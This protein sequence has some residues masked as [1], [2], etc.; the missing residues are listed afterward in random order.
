[1]NIGVPQRRGPP[2]LLVI[3][4]DSNQKRGDGDRVEREEGHAMLGIAGSNT[5][6]GGADKH[7]AEICIAPPRIVGSPPII[8]GCQK[9]AGGHQTQI[10][11]GP[12]EQIDRGGE[13]EP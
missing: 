2:T 5:F 11:V 3:Q 12:V 10:I 9:D 6:I 7:C 4:M 13:C 1:M 8:D